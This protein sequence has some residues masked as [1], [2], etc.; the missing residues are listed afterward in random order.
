MS[1]LGR[2]RR[3]DDQRIRWGKPVGGAK[4]GCVLCDLKI[5]R[6]RRQVRLASDER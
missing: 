1:H 3:A 5:H 2:E 6:D 4:E